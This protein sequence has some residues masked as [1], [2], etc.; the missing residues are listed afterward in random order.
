MSSFQQ[1][2]KLHGIPRNRRA[3]PIQRGKQINRNCLW[4]SDGKYTRQGYQKEFKDLKKNMEKIK[5]YKQDENMNKKLETQKETKKFLS[6]KVQQ[7]KNSL[8][9]FKGRFEQAEDSVNLKDRAM[10]II[11]SENRKR[12]KSKQSVSEL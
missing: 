4:R 3:E 12:P 9:G 6:W 7:T 8:E 11:E 1:W 5:I 2:K 10:E